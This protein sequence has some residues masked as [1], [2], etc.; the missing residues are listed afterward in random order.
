MFSLHKMRYTQNIKFLLF[1]LLFCPFL[2][3]SQKLPDV[4]KGTFVDTLNRYYHNL[5]LPAFLSISASEEEEPTLLSLKDSPKQSNPML[6][7]YFKAHGKQVLHYYGNEQTKQVIADFVVYVDGK[8]PKTIANF[9]YAPRF[10]SSSK[11]FFGKG[12]AVQISASDDLS[13]VN[14]TYVSMNFADFSPS[15]GDIPL[16]DEGEFTLQY[17]SS[18][19][20]GNLE[21]PNK[22]VFTIDV[23]PPSTYHNVVGVAEN[24]VISAKTKIYLTVED[25]L[26]GVHKTYYQID[27][28]LKKLYTKGIIPISQLEDGEHTITYYSVDNVLNVEEVK[29]YSFYLDKTSPIM[30]ADVLGDR[31]IV[32]DKVYFSGR[33]KL[34]LTAVDNKS[35]VKEVLY[36]VDGAPYQKYEDP[37]YMPSKAGIHSIKYFAL[38]NMVNQGVGDSKTKYEEYTH[39]SSVVYVDLTGPTLTHSFIGP[40]FKRGNNVYISSATRIKLTAFD[41]ESGLQKITYSLDGGQNEVLY[42]EAFGFD[43]DI[44]GQIEF[45]AYDN[46]NNRNV[47]NVR[48]L[49]DNTGPELFYKYS[50]Q[51]NKDEEGNDVYPSY[52]SLFIGASD[53]KTG[54]DQIFYSINEGAEKPYTGIISG[55]KKNEIYKIRLRALDKLGNESSDELIIKTDKY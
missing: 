34:K 8:S 28:G 1:G 10:V 20:V 3:Y 35:G 12:L 6:P 52:L 11:V 55:F 18:D 4:K 33:T 37:F 32:N 19:N 46:V 45:Y 2:L 39:N 22:R 27:E 30:T 47:G 26:S 17:L 5:E 9:K 54:S 16:F 44:S 41:P 14:E 53:S 24:N 40:K 36:S 15:E 48:F 13:G 21:N 23:T 43:Q 7:F 42:T 50:V 29:T 49:V 31:F 51:A 25:N 38:D